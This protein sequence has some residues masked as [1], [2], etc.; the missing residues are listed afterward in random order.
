M[1]GFAE[2][3]FWNE[4]QSVAKETTSRMAARRARQTLYIVRRWPSLFPFTSPNIRARAATWSQLRSGSQ[5]LLIKEAGANLGESHHGI[6]FLSLAL[7]STPTSWQNNDFIQTHIGRVWSIALY[8][9]WV[10][11]LGEAQFWVSTK[12]SQSVIIIIVVYQCWAQYRFL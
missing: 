11:T 12:S 8:E 1:I 5:C 10:V 4:T 3:V 7:P 6:S 9:D 2:R